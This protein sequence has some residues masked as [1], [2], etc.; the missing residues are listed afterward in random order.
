MIELLLSLIMAGVQFESQSC[1]I[2]DLQGW[3]KDDIIV[4]CDEVKDLNLTLKHEAIHF[5]QD[6][7]G[8]KLL[9]DEEL[10]T[11]THETLS[12]GEVLFVLS[13]YDNVHEELEARVLSR[14][15]PESII[16]LM[17]EHNL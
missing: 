17:E 4:L 16:Q 15:S 13:V 2:E 12:D 14:Q 9:S 7:C 3:Y 10:T 6:R 8:C 5:I 11:M 1:R